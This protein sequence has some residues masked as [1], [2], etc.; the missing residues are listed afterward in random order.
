M[1]TI[2]VHIPTEGKLHTYNRINAIGNFM[3]VT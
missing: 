3:F 2:M 1:Q